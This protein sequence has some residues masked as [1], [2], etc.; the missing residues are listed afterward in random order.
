MKGDLEA[1]FL[2]NSQKINRSLNK[3]IELINI[4]E[5]NFT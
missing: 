2:K 3:D 4:N 1:K 5:E